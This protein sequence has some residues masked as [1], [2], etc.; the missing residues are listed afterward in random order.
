MTGVTKFAV[1]ASGSGTNFQAIYD[2]VQEG[3]T[4]W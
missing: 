2:A 3:K 1:F 4:R